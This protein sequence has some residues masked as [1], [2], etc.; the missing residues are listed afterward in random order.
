MWVFLLIDTIRGFRVRTVYNMSEANAE[1]MD[2]DSSESSDDLE[3]RV[4]VRNQESSKR[5]VKGS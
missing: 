1:R 2:M 4:T 3:Q 5:C